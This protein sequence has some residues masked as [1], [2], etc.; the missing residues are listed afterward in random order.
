MLCRD[1]KYLIPDLRIGG[2]S[3]ATRAALE[4][5]LAGCASCREAA[6]EIG[7]AV[8]SL[9][10]DAQEERRR[11]V[12]PVDLGRVL[13]RP[14]LWGRLGR[15]ASFAA[16]IAAF[17]LI[18]V[19]AVSLFGM[20]VRGEKGT[21][22][23]SFL[24]PGAERVPPSVP[25]DFAPAVGPSIRREVEA[26]LAPAFRDLIVWMS[27]AEARRARDLSTIAQWV[28]ERRSRDATLIV[29]ALTTTREDLDLTRTAV[30]E[31]AGQA[32]RRPGR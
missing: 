26:T 22:S 31:V 10:R 28:E 8:E 20:E 2:L 17:L 23:V 29:N 11:P 7:A 14:T 12:P 6:L 3:S 15:T 30:L 1:A 13:P 9:R 32:L 5:H 21:L 25:L 27:A 19:G 4:E 18:G 24:L 16:R